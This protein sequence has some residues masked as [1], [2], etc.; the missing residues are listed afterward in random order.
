MVNN[1]QRRNFKKSSKTRK[2]GGSGGMEFENP[3]YRG[4][5][6]LTVFRSG[7]FKEVVVELKKYT[8]N[9]FATYSIEGVKGDYGNNNS[10]N[11]A[12][13]LTTSQLSLPPRE[14]MLNDPIF[15]PS[16][17]NITNIY[18]EARE[19]WK[20]ASQVVGLDDWCIYRL[21]TV[22]IM[23]LDGYK[24]TKTWLEV[25][26]AAR[27]LDLVESIY[28]AFFGVYKIPRDVGL[29]ISAYEEMF[30]SQ[31]VSSLYKLI[32]YNSFPK[33]EE[34]F[35]EMEVKHWF[36]N[37]F[38][39]LIKKEKVDALGRPST[40]PGRLSAST[41]KPPDEVEVRPSTAPGQESATPSTAVQSPQSQPVLI[42]LV[43]NGTIEDVVVELKNPAADIFATE[44][45]EGV[46]EAGEAEAEELFKAAMEEIEKDEKLFKEWVKKIG[47]GPERRT[48]RW[49]IDEE[50][51]RRREMTH[52]LNEP[53]FFPS[54]NITNIYKEARKRWKNASLKTVGANNRWIYRLDTVEIMNLD[55]YK[56]TKTWL[57]VVTAA[58]ILDLVESIYYAFFGVYK[59]PRDVGLDISAYEEMFKSQVVS[60]LYKLINYN[61]FPKKEERFGE[62]EVKHWFENGFEELI[63]KEKVD[64]LGRPSTS[65]GRLSASTSKPPD[66]VEVRPS[67]APGQE[68]A[69]P[70]TAV[71]SPNTVRMRGERARKLIALRKNSALPSGEGNDGSLSGGRRKRRTRRY[72]KKKAKK[73]KKSK[74][75]RVKRS[76]VK[77]SR[78]KRSRGK[79]SR[80]GK[81]R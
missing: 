36:E 67:T 2:R 41:S 14:E 11:C 48:R 21:D 15:F 52:M 61:S 43:R 72:G 77:R 33:K 58:R 65:P 16:D 69:T 7:T 54:D 59:I 70:S 64:A 60:S 34:R 46:E 24:S 1:T 37:G 68:S 76:R 13:T 32:N 17:N 26:T 74:R 44:T 80:G 10:E 28:Y 53:I 47:E 8:V 25:V 23:N 50:M 27:I 39:E 40:S 66:E 73:S 20:N 56:S 81:R 22:E 30:K 38:E 35:G 19:R 79:R 29:D 6:D 51:R 12:D 18:K 3:L 57:E 71:Q 78:V 55:G 31:V 62:M 75:S 4:N 9:I 63:K 42:N 5:I 49:Q 45:I